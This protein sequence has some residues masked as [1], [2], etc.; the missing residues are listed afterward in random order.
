[1]SRFQ[2]LPLP[3]KSY[4]IATFSAGTALLLTTLLLFFFEEV[5]AIL[6]FAAAV[7]AWYAGL[8]FAEPE[9]EIERNI[10]SKVIDT[11]ACLIVVLDNQG[12]IVR[13]N[14]ACEKITGYSTA[15]VLNKCVWDVFLISE[16][17]EPVKTVF[18]KL[19]VENF[20]SEYQNY[21]RTKNRSISKFVFLICKI[22]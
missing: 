10:I 4:S 8:K 17:V 22:I 20:N 15:E 13:F 9:I 2:V 1:M 11:T 6:L 14:Q 5:P 19:N 3:I 16:E 18:T 21:W 12:R 7:I